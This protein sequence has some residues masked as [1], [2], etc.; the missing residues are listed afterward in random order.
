[1]PF[2]PSN[3][4]TSLARSLASGG[5]ETEIFLNS[6]TTKQGHVLTM[7]DIGD[8]GLLKLNP[9]ASNEEIISFTGID[10]SGATPKVTGVTRGYKDYAYGTDSGNLWPHS[11]SETVIITND[12]HFLSQQYVNVDDAQTINGLKTFANAN[13]PELATD[14]DAT[15]DKQFVTKGQLTR[16]SLAGASLDQQV[17]A[18]T[19][20]ETL[21]AGTIVYL[22]ESDQRWWKTDADAFLTCAN[23]IL[24]VAQGAATAGNGVN[25][26]VSGLEKNLSG[27]TAGAKYYISGTA[28]ALSTTVGAV[29][30]LVGVAI[31]TTRLVF[32]PDGLDEDIQAGVSG[33]AL[34]VGAM[35]YFKTSDQKWWKTDADAVATCLGVDI[36]VV[37]SATSGADQLVLIRTGGV[38]STQSGL[39]PGTKYY[40]SNT[41]AALASTAQTLPRYVGIARSAQQLQLM[42][43]IGAGKDIFGQ[44][45]YGTSTTGNDTYVVTLPFAPVALYNGFEFWMKPDTANTGAATVNVNGLGATSILRPDGSALA[46][47]DIAANGSVHLVY[48]STAAAFLIASPL[49]PVFKMG[50]TT[51]DMSTASGVQNIAHGLG[52][53]PKRIRLNGWY[54]PGSNQSAARC[55][56]SYNGTTAAGLYETSVV[57]SNTSGVA[58]TTSFVIAKGGGGD[59]TAVVTMDAT[60]II[61]TW[62][63][64]GTPTGTLQIAWEAQ[65]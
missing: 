19:A 8:L 51:Y 58:T 23:V 57:L 2:R 56:L 59:Q 42:P 1:M 35:A 62:T 48:N 33:E 10:T 47:G 38:D 36:G 7:S 44:S 37:Q 54:V 24:G 20:G 55:D 39:T 31:S 64:T 40:L 27:L 11:P 3:F 34:A 63:K 26:L 28:G 17:I 25:I 41:A 12:D 53:I 9:G 50:T 18:G 29:P 49:T 43:L 5:S 30:R 15:N 60:N 65:A 6:L 22:K 61:L 14:A 4:K 16:T 13:R 46:D 52:K 45:N 21:A 32:L